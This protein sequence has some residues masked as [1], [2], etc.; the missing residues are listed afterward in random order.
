MCGTLSSVD[1]YLN[2]KLK[3]V[4]VN[5]GEKHPH[6]VNK[7]LQKFFEFTFNASLSHIFVSK[8]LFLCFSYP[9]V[10]VSSEDPL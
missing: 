6:M 7:L 3:E 4:T 1:Q 2:L 5:D 10:I 8:I 9:L